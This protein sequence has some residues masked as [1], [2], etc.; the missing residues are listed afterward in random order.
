AAYYGADYFQRNF[1]LDTSAGAKA[2]SFIGF[3]GPASSNAANRSIQE[4]TAGWIITFLKKPQYGS[5]HMVNQVSYL[6]RSPS[7][8][9][10]GQPKNARSTMVWS[11]IRYNLP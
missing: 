5:L 10:L 3:G 1:F 11:D 7:V 6:T 9:S 4:P 2:N 8:V